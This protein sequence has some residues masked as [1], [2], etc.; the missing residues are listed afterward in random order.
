MHDHLGLGIL[1]HE[2]RESSTRVWRDA[3]DQELASV[4]PL[5]GTEHA[6]ERHE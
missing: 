3:V 6:G 4:S 2:T 1:E 5:V